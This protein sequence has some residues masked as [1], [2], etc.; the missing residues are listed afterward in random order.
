MGVGKIADNWNIPIVTKAGV[1]AVNPRRRINDQRQCRRNGKEESLTPGEDGIV[2]FEKRG[3]RKEEAEA[4][5]WP[6]NGRA[7]WEGE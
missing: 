3:Q 2:L 5:E 4:I 1:M 7:T 6:G